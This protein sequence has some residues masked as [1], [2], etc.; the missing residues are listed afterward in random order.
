MIAVPQDTI[1]KCTCLTEC[2]FIVGIVSRKRCWSCTYETLKFW[3]IWTFKVYCMHSRICSTPQS[4][5]LAGIKDFFVLHCEIDIR[6]D[7]AVCAHSTT[8]MVPVILLTEH[9]L[10]DSQLQVIVHLTFSS[11]PCQVVVVITNMF[12]LCI[13]PWHTCLVLPW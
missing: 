10:Q 1:I 4:I 12:T 9:V 6:T 13:L 3:V 8:Y 5:I 7:L 2:M 11:D